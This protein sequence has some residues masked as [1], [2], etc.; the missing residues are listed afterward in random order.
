MADMEVERFLLPQSGR[1]LRDFGG[2]RT[3]GGRQVRRRKIFRSGAL[4]ALQP[5]EQS[6][7]AAYGIQCIC[8]LRTTAER[9]RD[10]IRE[11]GSCPLRIE[12]DYQFSAGD[13]A[14]LSDASRSAN[15]NRLYMTKAYRKL[16]L[17]QAPGL[18]TLLEC[19]A[20]GRTPL[21]VMC[22]GGKDRTGAAAAILLSL[23]GVDFEVVVQD[24]LLSNL[25]RRQSAFIGALALA[26]RSEQSAAM[27]PF[28]W[29]ER[30]YL[31]AMFDEI[32]ER[33]GGLLPYATEVVGAS[34]DMLSDMQERLFDAR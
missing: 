21:I 20:V 22:A 26:G 4:S 9:Q 28:L 24:Y 30:P 19:L 31:E 15:D 25:V 3:Q 16:P 23:L 1:N 14:R 5:S 17:E 29:V 32:E 12:R 8:D 7:I 13:L 10:P 33:F 34:A 18:Y 2:Y 6:V 27:E 11:F